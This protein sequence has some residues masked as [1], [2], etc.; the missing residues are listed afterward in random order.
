[1]IVIGIRASP[2]FGGCSQTTVRLPR[3][4]S[5]IVANPEDYVNKQEHPGGALLFFI[6]S[7][8]V[9]RRGPLSDHMTFQIK[10]P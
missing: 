4:L 1:M 3:T 9:S 5:F 6:S 8:A 7:A 2:P 10:S